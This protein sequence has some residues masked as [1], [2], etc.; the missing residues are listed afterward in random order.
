MLPR[1]CC[2]PMRA[3]WGQA[4]RRAT[5][6]PHRHLAVLLWHQVGGELCCGFFR[7][8]EHASSHLQ[9]VSGWLFCQLAAFWHVSQVVVALKLHPLCCAAR[10]ESQPSLTPL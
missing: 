2:L 3:W 8:C 4:S 10:F 6:Q 1:G 7:Y 9:H 5:L